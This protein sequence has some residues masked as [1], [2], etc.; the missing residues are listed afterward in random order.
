M[1]LNGIQSDRSMRP[2]SSFLFDCT[3]SSQENDQLF[4]EEILKKLR[5]SVSTCTV[6]KMKSLSEDSISYGSFSL[7]FP[8]FSTN[9]KELTID[10]IEQDDMMISKLMYAIQSRSR[11]KA[12]ALKSFEDA[13]LFLDLKIYDSRNT[14]NKKNGI[15]FS[16]NYAI[17]FIEIVPPKFSRTS[18]A[19]PTTLT[20]RFNSIQRDKLSADFSDSADP[21]RD[22]R[23]L[24]SEADTAFINSEGLGE[25]VKE[26]VDEFMN[27]S[28]EIE[29]TYAQSGASG[30][31]RGLFSM[32]EAL[33]EEKNKSLELPKRSSDFILDPIESEK[34]YEKYSK[35]RGSS[36]VSRSDFETMSRENLQR[37]QKGFWNANAE[38]EKVGLKLEIS[39][40]N[41]WTTHEVGSGDK[42]SHVLGQKMDVKLYRTDG[43]RVGAG[44]L[45]EREFKILYT[46]LE[47][48]GL[49][50]NFESIDPEKKKVWMDVQ[51]TSAL[52]DSSGKLVEK[53]FNDTWT[54]DRE[55][56]V[57]ERDE[58]SGV[59][60]RVGTVDIVTGESVSLSKKTR[61]DTNREYRTADQIRRDYERDRNSERE[62][63]ERSVLPDRQLPGM[64][65]SDAQW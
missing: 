22:F 7:S 55:V 18:D 51:L 49:K 54:G 64:N 41:S 20:A 26:W 4:T 1:K 40:V 42:P 65:Q 35:K 48:S 57:F 36:A 53:K 52:S 17:K 58:K 29:D 60:K 46:A 11:W 59:D 30:G 32:R 6:P 47:K 9:E 15:L 16:Q 28:R 2:L 27:R 33:R 24:D 25:M 14:L 38:L 13:D 44:D 50:S 19:M 10:F 23:R 12:T 34:N 31:G 37:L 63:M 56:A 21:L 5:Y 45:T 8:F 61:Y 3:F 62:E 39:D 43:T